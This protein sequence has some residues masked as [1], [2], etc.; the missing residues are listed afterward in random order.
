MISTLLQVRDLRTYFATDQGEARAVDGM[1]FEVRGG[2]TVALVGESGCGKSVTALSVLRLLPEPP[3]QLLAGSSVRL[4]GEE[5]TA[6][7]ESR[8]REVRGGELSESRF[9]ARHRG[10]GPYWE[11]I[12]SLFRI[13]AR[14]LGFDR[15]AREDARRPAPTR[16]GEQL[17]LF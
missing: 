4:R 3:G 13:H 7:A 16:R 17:A 11:A 8:L 10:A 6:A 2:E 14:R 5:L 12:D 15:T 1:S 9:G